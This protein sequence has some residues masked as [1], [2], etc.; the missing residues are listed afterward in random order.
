MRKLT[1]LS[2]LALSFLGISCSPNS[3][4]EVPV[5]DLK[6]LIVDTL[7]LEKDTLTKNLKDHFTYYETDSGQ[8]LATFINHQLLVYT[9]PD[10]KLLKKQRYDKEVPDGIGS[11]V[12][13]NYIDEETIYFLSQ[14]KELIECDFDGKVLNRWDFPE[15][16]EARKYAN[17]SMAGFNRIRRS[18]NKLLFVDFPFVFQA[19]FEDY[20]NWGMIFNTESKTFHISISY[21]LESSQNILMMTNW[22]FLATSIFQQTM[23]T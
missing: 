15:I 3:Q 16:S 20:D 22:V 10:G 4:K 2:S 9:F 14:Q 7:H 21:I 8:I 19:G 17:Y 1:L 23:N 12:T 6:D 5:L 11:F 18:G 13:G